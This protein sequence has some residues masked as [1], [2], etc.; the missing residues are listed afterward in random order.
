[1]KETG[2]DLFID[3]HGDEA[4]PYNFIAGNEGIPA[5]DDRL[6]QLQVC[7]K[8]ESRHFFDFYCTRMNIMISL[9]E[10]E[11]VQ[12]H[13]TCDRMIISIPNHSE[14]GQDVVFHK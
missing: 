5:W 6:Q 9:L 10:H 13:I 12:F 8:Y 1:M 3:V 7:D 2:C 14:A 11:Y 4:L